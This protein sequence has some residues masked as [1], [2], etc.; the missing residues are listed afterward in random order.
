[1][2]FL[3]RHDAGRQLARRL[4]DYRAARPVVLA[5]PRGGAP[6][7]YEIAR[8]L[9]APLE[10]LVARKL[11]EPRRRE[12]SVGAIAPGG[13]L[14]LDRAAIAAHGVQP[15][16]LDRIVAEETAELARRQDRYRL[17]GPPVDLAG[18]TAILVDDGLATGLTAL[19]AVQAVRRRRPRAVV[20]ATPVCAHDAARRLRDQVDELVYVES[21]PTFRAVGLWYDDFAQTTDEEVVAL[22]ERARRPGTER[23]GPD[24]ARD[25]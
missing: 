15:G 14:L 20:V 5:L 7:G 16:E 10:V 6:V 4:L 24:P 23:A 8:A 19:A 18:R 2:R 9:G 17:D 12:D 11:A 22:L 13:V 3:D 21:P 1:M 25:V